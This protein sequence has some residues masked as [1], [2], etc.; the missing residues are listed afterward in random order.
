M[1]AVAPS[2]GKTQD[3]PRFN[4]TE[5][6][7]P[8]HFA[9]K[10]ERSVIR[11]GK[12]KSVSNT[13][14]SEPKSV[15]HLENGLINSLALSE[16]GDSSVVTG[17]SQLDRLKGGSAPDANNNTGVV[18]KDVMKN[19]ASDTSTKGGKH[20]SSSN[21]ALKPISLLPFVSVASTLVED[22]SADR[23]DASG[24]YLTSSSST[25]SRGRSSMSPSSTAPV[26]PV[27]SAMVEAIS[28]QQKGAG[29]VK[30]RKTRNIQASAVGGGE[31]KEYTSSSQLPSLRQ[32]S[33]DPATNGSGLNG[34]KAGK[35]RDKVSTRQG[36]G[37]SIGV[38]ASAM[39]DALRRCGLN[40]VS[41]LSSRA[42]NVSDHAGPSPFSYTRSMTTVDKS[43]LFRL[44]PPES[45][46]SSASPFY[47]LP[48]YSGGLLKPDSSTSYSTS[49]P[50]PAQSNLLASLP[51]PTETAPKPILKIKL[52]HGPPNLT[53]Q[54][55]LGQLPQRALTTDDVTGEINDHFGPK[56]SYEPTS[57]RYTSS[58]SSSLSVGELT[59]MQL[60]DTLLGTEIN[61][62]PR[63]YQ[64]CRTKI[65]YVDFLERVALRHSDGMTPQTEGLLRSNTWDASLQDSSNSNDNKLNI[66]NNSGNSN[67]GGPRPRGIGG[68]KSGG[69]SLTL[70]SL[71]PRSSG[72]ATAANGLT[73]FG[74]G[75]EDRAS[76]TTNESTSS[77][78][79]PQI[80]IPPFPSGKPIL[81]PSS[82]DASSPVTGHR[83]HDAPASEPRSPLGNQGYAAR[84]DP[85]GRNKTNNV[86]G[87]SRSQTVHG[88]DTSPSN[89]KR[90][91]RFSISDQVR[92]FTPGEPAAQKKHLT[93]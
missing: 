9:P 48:N 69:N 74:S 36:G 12:K 49:L 57:N 78:P 66:K 89:K 40:G 63:F 45:S 22:G 81:K 42:Q 75:S 85:C 59:C 62:F 20:K 54:H 92:E 93:N 68:W 51:R 25:S 56:N 87:H 91:V 11:Y 90:A 37:S 32:S 5:P 70:P 33:G 6:Q 44:L 23:D 72:P 76:P 35:A 7:I 10:A 61:D 64:L 29:R 16:D 14:L 84:S 88:R 21:R 80:Y 17:N 71:A 34:Y 83:T 58:D 27:P 2:S 1:T 4:K 31:E 60:A 13:S 18:G 26:P 77:S 28:R 53:Q 39:E 43:V 8:Q 55:P 79:P 52:T 73:F 30:Y 41:V 50:R 46:F 47:S 3:V 86:S 19:D 24:L 82:Q 67:V 15:S 65:R 38:S